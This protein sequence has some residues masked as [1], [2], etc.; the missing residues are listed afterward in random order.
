MREVD[1]FSINLSQNGGANVGDVLKLF[2]LTTCSSH[3]AIIVTVDNRNGGG[4]ISPNQNWP[5]GFD[6]KWKGFTPLAGPQLSYVILEKTKIF[7]FSKTFFLIQLMLNLQQIKTSLIL[8]SAC[9]W[10]CSLYEFTT[11][12]MA[13]APGHFF[14]GHFF[15]GTYFRRDIFSTDTFSTT[16]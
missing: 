7:L 6:C 12:S 16:K 13:W 9:P 11:I 10:A 4:D 1:T 15:D 14:D 3:G 2:S 8:S 5:K